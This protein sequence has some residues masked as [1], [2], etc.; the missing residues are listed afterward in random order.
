VA[1]DRKVVADWA[2]I[3]GPPLAVALA[4]APAIK[5]WWG[6]WPDLKSY[7]VLDYTLFGAAV[8]LAVNSIIQ[9]VRVRRMRRQEQ[10][11]IERENASREQAR[12]NPEANITVDLA[13]V[14]VMI[15][16]EHAGN[17]HVI[18][19]INSKSYPAPLHFNG[20]A[21][22][23]VKFGATQLLHAQASDAGYQL[24]EI[25]EVPI[26]IP[27][28]TEHIATI[29]KAL[30]SEYPNEPG[31]LATAHWFQIIGVFKLRDETGRDRPVTVD[32]S[33]SNAIFQLQLDGPLALQ[34]LRAKSDKALRE[35]AGPSP[36]ALPTPPKLEPA[37]ELLHLDQL[38]ER[39]LRVFVQEP[40]D[41]EPNALGGLLQIHGLRAKDVLESL[42][43]LGLV[44]RD[45][46]YIRGTTYSLSDYGRRFLVD[47][48]WV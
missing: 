39:V 2:T 43:N 13:Q 17:I 1:F 19:K 10:A 34:A 21:V 14:G 36:R 6:S 30:P 46:N 9:S 42:R 24:P 47:K 11:R 3:I 40:T 45:E 15:Q 16:G 37:P 5:A 20:F 31:N 18:F 27:L 25:G 33:V 23:A 4:L 29:L 7:S 8:V 12:A 38:Q 44:R 41:I 26:D 32:R 48:N 28:T 22:T 35:I